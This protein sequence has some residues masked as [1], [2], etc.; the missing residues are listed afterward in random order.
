LQTDVLPATGGILNREDKNLYMPRVQSKNARKS[1]KQNFFIKFA[2]ATIMAMFLLALALLFEI[3][4]PAPPKPYYGWF[5][6]GACTEDNDCIVS[7]CNDE[8]C[9]SKT[10][11]SLVSVCIVP[12]KPLPPQLGYQCRCLNGACKWTK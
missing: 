4:A 3:F 12:D 1:S 6:A 10:E 9:Q 7:G 2:V 11:Q 5:T 8:I